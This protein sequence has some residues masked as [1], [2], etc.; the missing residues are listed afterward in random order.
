MYNMNAVNEELIELKR[1]FVESYE[2]SGVRNIDEYKSI[3]ADTFGL[4]ED[5][6]QELSEAVNEYKQTNN[7]IVLDSLI[8][9]N[10][11]LVNDE[12][13]SLDVVGL[14][15]QFVKDYL[16]SGADGYEEFESMSANVYALHEDEQRA[17]VAQSDLYTM[18]QDELELHQMLLDS[19]RK[20]NDRTVDRDI[21][22]HMDKIE[23]YKFLIG[24]F[25]SEYNLNEPE[26]DLQIT[27]IEEPVAHKLAGVSDSE[28]EDLGAQYMDFDTAM[29]E[30]EMLRDDGLV[31]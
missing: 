31:R 10:S 13:E 4:S 15:E 5:V 25:E 3:V 11:S 22:L 24:Q 1:K 7:Q 6:L 8:T 16:E 2:S 17:L 20:R 9:G 29:A 18:W 14:R 26:K 19:S 12:L 28:Y 23:D 21:N 27:E 30:M